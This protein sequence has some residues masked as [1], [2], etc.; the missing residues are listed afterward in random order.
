MRAPSFSALPNGASMSQATAHT[1]MAT[2]SQ[3]SSPSNFPFGIV[4]PMDA[5]SS[6]RCSFP[7]SDPPQLDAHTHAPVAGKIARMERVTIGRRPNR[8][9]MKLR[10]AARDALSASTPSMA[11]MSHQRTKSLQVE[12]ELS[13]VCNAEDLRT[14]VIVMNVPTKLTQQCFIDMLSGEIAGGFD[15]VYLPV[16][17][18]Q[19]ACALG[20]AFVNCTTMDSVAKVY[21]SF[22]GKA[23][24][25]QCN[26]EKVSATLSVRKLFRLRIRVR[27]AVHRCVLLLT[28]ESNVWR[29][30]VFAS[31]SAM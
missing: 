3:R 21:S 15:F 9:S 2:S 14:T 6:H 16:D 29:L 27:P 17:F 28:L 24:A 18:H 23:W 8:P 5:S 26:S 11:A 30:C 12:I 1:P 22:H 20:Y 13:R 7:R 31:A 4:T 19:P 25:S 10:A